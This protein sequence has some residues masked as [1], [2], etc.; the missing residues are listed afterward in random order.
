MNNCLD[1]MVNT[2]SAGYKSPY[3]AYFDRLPTANTLAFM[4]PEFQ[5]ATKSESKAERC[6]YLSRGWNHPLD[7]VKVLTPSG[8]TSDTRDVTWEMQRVSIIAVEPDTGMAT[9]P[10]A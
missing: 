8:L 9:A 2:A 7:S 10:E 3:E 5:R 1:T 4:W 6:F